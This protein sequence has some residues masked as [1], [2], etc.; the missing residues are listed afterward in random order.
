[1]A[2]KGKAWRSGQ[3]SLVPTH[4]VPGDS[5]LSARASAAQRLADAGAVDCRK[6][7]LVEPLFLSDLWSVNGNLRIAYFLAGG[8]GG[9][10]G[11]IDRP[12]SL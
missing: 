7:G 4:C 6:F 2:G 9:A 12:P 5:G 11:G 8:G 1:V 10:A 3:R